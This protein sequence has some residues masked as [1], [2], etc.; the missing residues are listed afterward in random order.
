MSSIPE[1]ENSAE[2]E[3]QPSC[4][5]VVD[6]VVG[7]TDEDPPRYAVVPAHVGV[8]QRAEARVHSENDGRRRGVGLDSE[9]RYRRE[10]E[11]DV[12]ERMSPV[13][14]EDAELFLRVVDGVQP[15][16][17][18][19]PVVDVMRQPVHRVDGDHRDHDE[20]PAGHARQPRQRQP[21]RHLGQEVAEAGP[22]QYDEQAP[23]ATRRTAG[24]RRRA[25]APSRAAGG[26]GPARAARSRRP[27]TRSRAR[28]DP[29][30]SY[31]P[32]LTDRPTP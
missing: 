11:A 26:A 28:P 8:R 25:G 32:A 31:L 24:S 16:E 17:H 12:H 1:R 3:I 6:A 15:P 18:G 4:R 30:S 20:A 7:G 29:A 13:G 27:R 22:E 21:G 2:I 23:R 10:Q 14:R 9:H 19:D 5:P